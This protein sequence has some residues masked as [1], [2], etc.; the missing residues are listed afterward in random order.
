[1]RVAVERSHIDGV[2]RVSVRGE[3]DIVSGPRV[4]EE[5]LRAEREAP[6][7]VVLD[8][9]GVTFFDSTGLQ[10]ILDAEVRAREAAYTFAV[11]PGGG[12]VLRVL[13]LAE[14]RGRLDLEEPAA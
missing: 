3:L 7:R 11:A 10:I 6:R 5:L 1:M 4:Q 2:V 9:T 13:E 12:E 14:V 8:L